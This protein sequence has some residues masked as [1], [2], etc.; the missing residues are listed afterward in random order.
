VKSRP[1]QVVLLAGPSGSGK[2]YIATS[3][4]FPVL[5]LDDFYKDGNDPTLPRLAGA[6]DWES[7]QA[8][9]STAAVE[10]IARLAED[11]KAEVPV[12][13][14]GADRR[15]ATRI[16]DLAGSPVFVAEGIFAAEIVAECERRGL[17]LKAYALRR[18]RLITFV[19]RLVRDLAERRKSPGVL[20]RRGVAL[21]RAEPRVL[22]RQTALGCETAGAGRI[23]RDVRRLTA[24]RPAT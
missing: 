17:L 2:S 7:P 15:V 22:R 24:D 5:C 18:P 9:D 6:V 10:T 8:W 16:L 23:V 19:R 20:L 4:G 3:T 21:L 1:V 13:A 11:G 12:Y 14:L